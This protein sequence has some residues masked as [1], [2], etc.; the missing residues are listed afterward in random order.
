MRWQM[1]RRSQ[2]HRG[3][4]AACRRPDGARRAGRRH[5]RAGHPGD[6]ADRHVPGRR[7]VDHPE[8]HV[9]RRRR[10]RSPQRC[11]GRPPAGRR[12]RRAVRRSGAGADRGHLGRDL[13]PGRPDTTAQPKLVL[14][15]GAVQSACGMAGSATG[16]FYC[17]ADQKVYLDLSFFDELDQQFGAPGDFAAGLRHRARGRPPRPD[18]ARHLAPGHARRGQRADEAT[19]NRLS[20]MME[21]QADCFAGRLGAHI[22]DDARGSSRKA[23]S[24]RAWTRPAP[25]ATTASRRP[26]AAMSCPTPSPTAARSSACAGSSRAS[27]PATSTAA[28]PSSAA[29]L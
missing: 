8:R 6:R 13:Q 10:R 9:R 25:S 26:R 16:P 20:V 29:Q 23:T 5:R 15:D 19:P 4:V 22:Q 17:P 21:L 1:G 18:P 24:R 11:A 27:R 14:F 7:P 28:T 3:P 2:Q 12:Q